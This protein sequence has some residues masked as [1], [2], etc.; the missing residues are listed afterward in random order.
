[1]NRKPSVA[2]WRSTTNDAEV[3][4]YVGS[5]AFTVAER[6]FVVKVA[7]IVATEQRA[8]FKR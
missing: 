7:T 4:R 3:R 6:W 5:I 8:Q 1:V 2:I